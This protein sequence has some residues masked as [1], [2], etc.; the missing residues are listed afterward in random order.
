MSQLRKGA[1]LSYANIFLT[2]VVGLVL[3][4]FIIR[5]LGDSEYGL[6]VL[7]GSLIAYVS[8]L[9]FGI[10]NT[11]VRF[12]AKYKVL[13]KQR[14][15]ANFLS[16]VLI[17][18]S[19]LSFLIVLIG[20][21]FYNNIDA[22]FTNLTNIELEKAKKLF[23]IL[24][25]NLALSLP[26]GTFNAICSAYERF[27]YVRLLNIIKYLLRTLLII[28]VLSIR[29]DSLYLVIL[30]TIL[31]IIF[32]LVTIFYVFVKLKVKIKLYSFNILLI[33]QIF[34]YSLW[35]FIYAIASQFQWQSGQIVLGII[36]GTKIV[37]VYSIGVLLGSYY[38][39]FSSAISGMFIPKAVQMVA[40]K[41]SATEMTDTMIL[42]GR[43]CMYVLLLIFGA[44]LLFGMDFISL[45]VGKE[46][47]DSWIITI[48]IM[49]G[50]T[51]P[52]IQ[53]FSNSI[54]EAMGKYAFKAILNLIFLILGVAL[55]FY[56]T[57]VNP[58]IGMI[59]GI[60]FCWILSQIIM[61]FYF[62]KV[63]KL[64]IGRF[65]KETFSQ[66]IY[67]Y[68]IV[69]LLSFMLNLITVNNWLIISIKILIYIFLFTSLSYK[70]CMNKYEKET[71]GSLFKLKK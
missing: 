23:I 57:K 3:T 65:F 25:V 11:V 63:I 2:N 37:A 64:E 20:L 49:I 44:F 41:N 45:W 9:D 24:L 36:S 14:N 51:T 52:L 47:K 29:A 33:K 59:S 66:M 58:T 61:N 10:N 1:I 40:N 60:C 16:V 6:Y 70:F 42:I 46:Y 7:V 39:T 28:A 50:Y 15:E 67:I 27:V 34:S 43:L 5:A 71:F 18:Y 31:N 26:G 48:I 54:L 8:I 17:I 30:D 22:V 68:P 12:V 32:I 13:K 55:G 4:P 56:L 21:Y 69:L 38:A 35:I 62:I 53:I 19:I